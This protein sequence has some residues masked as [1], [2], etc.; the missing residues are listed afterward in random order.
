MNL[1][2]R[3][4]RLFVAAAVTAGTCLPAAAADD[5]FE[6]FK[7]EAQVVT[8]SRRA[9]PAW[10]APVAV[11][12]ITADEIKAY[13]AREIWDV[14]RYRAGMDVVDGRSLDGNRALVS[15][16]GFITEF[17]A[18]MQVLVDG[19]SVYSPLLG[20]VYWQ[21]LPVQMQDIERIEIVRGP[22]AALYGSN[23]ALGVINIITKKA[24]TSGAA[25]AAAEGGDRYAWKTSVAADAARPDSGLRVSYTEKAD[26][27]HLSSS[28]ASNAG[29]FLHQGNL[30][31][32][33]RW[34]PD[35]ATDLEVQGG[36]TW[37]TAGLPVAGPV[38]QSRQS[39]NFGNVKATRKLG[40]EDAVEMTLSRAENSIVSGPVFAGD[41]AV[42]TYQ[43][44][45][46]LLHRFTW[47][48]GN[49]KSNWGV[50]WRQMGADSVQVFGADPR[51]SNRL[52]RAFTHQ[53]VRLAEPLTL[54]AG[55]SL[56][57]SSTG[58]TQAAGQG[59]FVLSP[60]DNHSLRLSY[61]YAPTIP[62]LVESHARYLLGPGRTYVGTSSFGPERTSS[63]E[64][65]W[66][67]RLLDGALTP[68]VALYYMEVRDYGALVVA[69][70]G[71]L[72]TTNSDRAFARGVELSADYSLAPGRSLFVNYTYERITHG[73]GLN[74]SGYDPSHSTPDHKFNVGARAALP[75]GFTASSVVG[76][77]DD[78][79][80]NSSSRG[81][82]ASIPRHFRLDARLGWTPRPGWEVFV[83]GE[84]LLQKSFSEYVDGTATPRT[85]RGGVEARFGR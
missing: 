50:E 80:A 30:N 57:H 36:G 8:A 38:A 63:T 75:H 15:A 17:V 73:V 42:R 29:D 85:V 22:N 64:L 62:P 84:E 43:Y 77:K 21:S 37:L 71:T 45:A 18:E 47:R 6:F 49:V 24:G 51:Q 32:A 59:A 27:G 46:G 44:D 14:L 61:S 34:S 54:V 41:V 58:G 3:P 39:Q 4:L 40:G 33:G 48:D 1:P 76:Y 56:E 13:G 31:A 19:R 83:S 81:S 55:V 68:S 79:L 66:S 78:Y 9:E 72:T 25:S 53:T 82:S 23:A 10:K 65:G 60:A 70:D 11:D 52:V 16:R 7:E 74:A 28:G 69:P 20:G 2:Q 35:D 12:V 26:D 67:S 5:A